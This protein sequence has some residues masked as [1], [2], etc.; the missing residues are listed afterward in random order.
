LLEILQRIVEG[1]GETDDLHRLQSLGENIIQ[2]SLC[3]LGQT[4]PNPILSTLKFFRHEYELHV[5]N[6]VCPAGVCKALLSYKVIA[7]K[8]KACGICKKACPTE[9]ITGE[10]KQAHKIDVSKCAQC[11]VCMEKCPFDAIKRG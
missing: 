7:D 3:G 2:S 11:G 4:A 10:K 6:K 9:A 1:N 8:C 5:K